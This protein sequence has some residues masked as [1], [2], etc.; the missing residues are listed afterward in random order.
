MSDPFI[1]DVFLSHNQADKPRVHRLAERLKA[2]GLRVWLDD[3]V[4]Q[5][6]DDIFLA[7]ERGLEAARVQVLCL[8]PAALYSDWVTLERS[9]VLFRDPTNAGHRF[10]PLLLDDC[11]LPDALRRYKYVDFREDAE[12]EFEK[13][14]NAC[15]NPE[16]WPTTV[17]DDKPLGVKQENPFQTAGALPHDHPTYIRRPSDDEFEQVLAGSDRLISITGDFYIGKSSLMLQARRILPNHLF[18]GRGLAG[19]RSDDPQKFIRN[20]FKLFEYHFGAIDDWDDL[21]HRASQHPSILFLDDLGEVL[22]PGLEAMIPPL[23]ERLTNPGSGL[24]AI[25]TS[26][27]KLATI[28]ERREIY[29]P[30]FSK[31]WTYIHVLPFRDIEA[32]KLLF[33]L[34]PRVRELTLQRISQIKEKSRL[35]PHRLQRLCKNLFEAESSGASNERL[36]AIIMNAESYE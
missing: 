29:D 9:T 14:L 2:A 24:R 4:I 20:F 35:M 30:K 8:S 28:F 3:W 34:P 11:E 25:T 33:L 36:S 31:P 21:D 1:Y 7:I 19:L 27:Q 23:I 26:R 13:L 12:A 6:G 10:I 32:Q 17:E 15:R 18:F 16:L 22:A 5:L